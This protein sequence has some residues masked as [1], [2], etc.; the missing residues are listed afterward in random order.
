MDRPNRYVALL[1]GI[2]V[3]GKNRLA[4][5]DLAAICRAAGCQDVV[6]YIQSGNVVFTADPEVAATLAGVVTARIAADFGLRVP[7]ILRSIAEV[8][9]VVESNPLI[10]GGLPVDLL[11]VMFLADQ[12]TPDRLSLLDPERSP[13]DTYRLVGREVY[14]HLPNGVA[15]S[16]LTNAYVDSKLGTIST[17]R[18]WRTVIKLREMLRG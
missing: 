12:P 16:K 1:R 10:A 4:M 6:T 5:A 8:E 15:G 7:V 11:H 3:G 13:L 9:S 18:N 2:N 14:L 17:S